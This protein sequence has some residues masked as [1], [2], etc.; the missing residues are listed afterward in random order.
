MRLDDDDER[1]KNFSCFG[2]A[3]FSVCVCMFE[4]ESTTFGRKMFNFFLFG[5]NSLIFIRFLL[6]LFL[7]TY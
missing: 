1:A 2:V 3:V 4:T 5:F 6:R 7:G